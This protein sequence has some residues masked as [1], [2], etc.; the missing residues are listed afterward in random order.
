M[1]AARLREDMDASQRMLA[2]RDILLL[3]TEAYEHFNVTVSI[4]LL[5]NFYT[6]MFSQT[7][8]VHDALR[9]IPSFIET[10][11]ANLQRLRLEVEKAKKASKRTLRCQRRKFFILL[12][13][14]FGLSACVMGLIAIIA[15]FTGA[16]TTTSPI[17]ASAAGLLSA[18]ALA[19][20]QLHS[21]Y[22]LFAFGVL[23]CH[24]TLLYRLVARRGFLTGTFRI[25]RYYRG[26]ASIIVQYT[27][28]GEYI[29]FYAIVGG[30]YHE[31]WLQLFHSDTHHHQRWRHQLF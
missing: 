28:L 14:I 20:T 22:F 6:R 5:E 7:V 18:A 21:E 2:L 1:V 12:T 25:T 8:R 3:A 10:A 9:D 19:C 23:D 26:A 31:N 4:N 17:L 30:G 27:S 15:L 24:V 13:K 16:G 11:K 29:S